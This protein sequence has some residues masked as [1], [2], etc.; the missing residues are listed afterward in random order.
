MRYTVPYYT[1][2]YETVMSKAATLFDADYYHQAPSYSAI[3]FV[4]L[5]FI[6][7]RSTVEFCECFFF[8][9]RFS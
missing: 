6:V 9:I 7:F 1:V 2:L 5:Q 4:T 3:N 8:N